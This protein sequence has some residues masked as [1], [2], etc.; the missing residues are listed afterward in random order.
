MPHNAPRVAP[1]LAGALACLLAF[2]AA[3]RQPWR[4]PANATAGSLATGPVGCRDARARAAA[5]VPWTGASGP[6]AGGSPALAPAS[7]RPV[8]PTLRTVPAK[9]RKDRQP[10]RQGLDGIWAGHYYYED[11][12]PPVPIR[13]VLGTSPSGALRG[14][15]TE[16]RT[17]GPWELKVL[18]ATLA[19]AWDPA[20]RGVSWEKHYTFSG[21]H[22]VWYRG[23]LD[24]AGTRIDGHWSLPG[25][26][27]RFVL[28]RVQ[29]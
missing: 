28:V 22:S 1:A 27:G 24:A 10:R 15:M 8:P 3:A 21:G 18:E 20:R 23:Q 11:D 17:F 2:P 5:A 13:A 25:A 26:S 14:R 4:T 16:P 12:R 29:R 7:P 9:I 19:G 6:D